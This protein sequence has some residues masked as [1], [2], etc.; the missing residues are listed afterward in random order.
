MNDLRLFTAIDLPSDI[1]RHLAEL[2]R[3]LRARKVNLRWV[4]PENIHLTLV[5]LGDTPDSLV[6]PIGAA[7]ASAMGEMAPFVLEV[8]GLGVFPSYKHP[9]V[10]WAGVGGAV[11][12]AASIKKAL[13]RALAQTTGLK[14]RPERR[15][16]KPHLTLGRAKGHIAPDSLAE[17]SRLWENRQVPRFVVD[18][19]HLIRSRLTSQGARY[20]TL[21]SA[22]LAGSMR[23]AIS[24]DV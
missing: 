10:L 24:T 6:K 12:A 16:Y 5:F 22:R 8:K 13:D 17:V 21:H 4:P 23:E 9:R 7:M 20:N 18:A 2:Q 15:A 11:V 19:V 3:E 1:R 14:Y